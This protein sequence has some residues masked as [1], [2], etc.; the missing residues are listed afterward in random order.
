MSTTKEDMSDKSDEEYE[1]GQEIQKNLDC[2]GTIE[3]PE[4]RMRF[5]S[6]ENLF[7]K[8]KINSIVLEHNH[9]LSSQKSRFY[10]CNTEISKGAQRRLELNDQ[11]GIGVAKN[12]Q[13]FV[14]EADGHDNVPFLKK[15]CRNY[16]DKIRKL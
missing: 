14:V 15:D 9:D 6:L 2:N 13:S 12:F 7:L 16:I 5:D 11:A 3:A 10:S 8:C 1:D 4:V